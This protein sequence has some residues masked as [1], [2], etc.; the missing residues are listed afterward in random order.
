MTFETKAATMTEPDDDRPLDPA[1]MLA[2]LERQKRQVD[3]AYVTPVA[4]LYLV[5][6][7]S[8]ALGFLL[9]WLARVVDWMPLSLAGTVFGVLIVASIITS[10]IDGTRIGR[11]V[12]GSSNFQGAVYGM[13]WS[14][15]GAAFA[16]VGVGLLSNGMSQELAALYF[17]SAYA[18]MAGIMYLAGAALWS[19][20]SQLVLGCVLLVVGSIAP[21]FGGPTNN[22]VMA[23]GGGG[24]FLVAA[25]HFVLVIRSVR[26]GA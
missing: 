23:I 17:P 9:L 3:L 8:W 12:R 26:R 15:S 10:A 18:L 4:W 11:G 21:F 22:L 16:A 5:W 6:G 13:S 2:L 14:L 20:K 19:E 25:A 1:E 24:S 7:V